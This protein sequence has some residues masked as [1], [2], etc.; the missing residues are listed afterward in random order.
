MGDR[1]HQLSNELI[2]FINEQHMFFVATAT[3]NSKINISPKDINNFRV[4]DKNLVLWLNLTGSSNETAAHIQQDNRMT[5]MFCSF[6]K[7]PMILRLYGRAIIIKPNDKKW[8]EAYKLFDDNIGAR[9]IFAIDIDLVQTSCGFGVPLFN[10]IS[11]R[12]TLKKWSK[13][14]GKDGINEYQQQKN[15]I[16]LDGAD[17]SL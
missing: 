8:Q 2:N 7:K 10:Y 9:Q 16:S 1:Y 12:D 6:T 14:K 17:I 15:I 5:I 11:D 3:T 13:Q 4:I